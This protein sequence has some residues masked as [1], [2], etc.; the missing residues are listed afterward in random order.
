MARVG[1]S[2]SLRVQRLLKAG[3]ALLP[4]PLCRERLPSP[5]ESAGK[6][7]LVSLWPGCFLRFGLAAS[8]PTL[9]CAMNLGEAVC[10]V[11]LTWPLRVS[12]GLPK[13]FGLFRSGSREGEPGREKMIE[14]MVLRPCLT[15]DKS[16]PLPGSL[17]PQL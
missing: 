13:D 8:T 2:S 15:L 4:R 10:Q 14:S 16:H 11:P 1:C 17:I 6:L 9:D 3:L 12:Q 5:V 7:G